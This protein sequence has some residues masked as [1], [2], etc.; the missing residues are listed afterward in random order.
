MLQDLCSNTQPFGGIT[1]VFGGDFHQT[2]PVVIHGTREDTINATLQRSNL[3]NS[4]KVLHLRHNMRLD[5]NLHRQTFSHWLLHIG[6]GQSLNTTTPAPFI[7]IPQQMYCGNEVELI[8]SIYGLMRE[9]QHIP[10]PDFFRDR[11]ILA[12]RNKDI[13]SLN[14]LILSHLLGK[15]CMYISADSYTIE[16]P[17]EQQNSNIPIEFLHSLNALGL[18]IS[19]L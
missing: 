15:Q 17:T 6:R 1:V 13:H 8:Q 3:W 14:S 18:P 10:P 4:I 16:S 5:P 12:A 19:E 7:T 2:L 11:A 9:R